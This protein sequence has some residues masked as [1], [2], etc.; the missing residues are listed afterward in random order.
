M[1]RVV[2]LAT[3]PERAMEMYTASCIAI[4][5]DTPDERAWLDKLATR[6]KLDPALTEEIER[7]VMTQRPTA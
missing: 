1:E 6:L 7:S 5:L 2:A 4:D 3:T